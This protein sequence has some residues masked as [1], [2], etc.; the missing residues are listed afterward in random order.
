MFALLWRWLTAVLVW[1]SSDPAAI[2]A[3]APKAAAACAVAYA[4]FADAAGPAPAPAPP[5]PG[6]CC[7]DCAG[8]GIIRH[9]DGHTTPCPCPSGCKCKAGRAGPKNCPG[10]NCAP[11][12][13]PAL[14]KPASH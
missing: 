10:G 1:L 13:S 14:T 12:A 6:K 5:T 9:G 3:E 2:D 7:E 8:T 4:A 11:A